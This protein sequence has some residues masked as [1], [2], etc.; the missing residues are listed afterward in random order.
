MVKY[1]SPEEIQ[2]LREGGKIIATILKELEALVKVGLSTD[3]INNKAALLCASHNVS[4]VF[5]GY[6]PQGAKRP[7]PAA[8]CVSIN[9]EIVH[10]IPNENP[11]ILKEGDVVSLDMGIIYKKMVLDSAIT[12]PVG[13]I[14]AAAIHLLNITK[15]ALY[16]G[17]AQAVI[18]NRIGDIG[19][20]IEEVA[21]SAGFSVADDLCGHGVG[22]AIHEDP[23]IPNVG[24]RGTGLILE[25]G[26]VIAIEPMFCEKGSRIKMGGDGYT[27][28]TKDGGRSAHFEHTIAITKDGPLILSS[29]E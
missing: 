12:V 25:E 29:L 23:F 2:V 15:D 6:K 20:A 7:Y 16:I 28:L 8:I 3:E 4:P 5:L 13:T 17:I 26:L 24:R 9:D 21:L 11:K 27:L 22:Y 18:G 10:G 19:A 14:D 1:K